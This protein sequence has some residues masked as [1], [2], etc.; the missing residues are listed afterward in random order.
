MVEIRL[1]T[2]DDIPFLMALEEASFN[3]H[4]RFSKES[5]KRSIKSPTQFVYIIMKG[6]KSV[7][8]ATLHLHKNV[9][10]LYSFAVLPAYR[11]HHMGAILLGEIIKRA[12][13]KYLQKITL[14]VNSE[15]TSAIRFYERFG[16]K[17]VR[18]LEDYYGPGTTGHKM[19]LVF[20][21]PSSKLSNIVVIDEEMPFLNEVPGITII[22]AE[23]FINDPRFQN[24]DFRVFNL[25]SSYAYQTTGYYVSLFAA[26]R[27]LR[28][29]PNIATIEDFN[30]V[31]I[32]DTISDEA[33]DLIRSTFKNITEKEITLNVIF[34]K[35]Q[36]PKYNALAYMLYKLF[37]APFLSFLFINDRRWTIKAIMP[38]APKVVAQD[39]FLLSSAISFFAQKKFMNPRFKNYKYDLA[40]LIDK[41]DP[42]PPS[43]KMALRR[44]V[45]AAKKMGFYTEF[46]T[47]D[48]YHLI[49]QFDALFIR[50][51]TNPND[52]T[53]QFS[54]LAYA[55]GLVVIDDPWSILRCANK[56]YLHESMNTH[57]IK[58]P[59]TIFVTKDT[60]LHMITDRLGFPVVLKRPDSSASLGV[61]KA[62]NLDELQTKLNTLF[63]T[64]DIILAQQFIKSDFDWRV[65]V[66]SNKAI[67]VCKYYM[68]K[69]HWQI[70][71]WK[72][73][74]KS[75][76][77]GG[78]K[79]LLVEEAPKKVI[80]L[81]LRASEIM[82]DGFYG[83]DIKEAN[84]E[85]YLIEVN[86]NPSV[87]RNWED[88]RLGDK[89]YE[90]IMADLYKRI[91]DA[92]MVRTRLSLP[93]ID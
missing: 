43:N 35:A 4:D 40:I 33:S 55:E 73:G 51:T 74:T 5:I 3:E 17:F 46:I 86:D 44:F 11:K 53:Y 70:Y 29:V 22:S 24:G 92:R 19:E 69:G 7:G 56:V 81:A 36:N 49:R 27:E 20:Y 76:E 14:E 63:A 61:F 79:T 16:F 85:V 65:G 87:D 82:G 83:V 13:E 78:V 62:N 2:L 50:T 39:D 58:T 90:L 8:S 6:T 91:E 23:R 84:G 72:P 15:N 68:A 18:L 1:A 59:T 10:R 41:E 28:A 67:Y 64:S 32:I 75:F 54:R 42:A 34:G 45:K 80:D 9:W 71:N 38:L 77:V 93:D 47:K 52:Y 30:D 12:E 60:S 37:P 57:N 48:D 25:C 31:T 26:A 21:S 88:A 89:L 66:L